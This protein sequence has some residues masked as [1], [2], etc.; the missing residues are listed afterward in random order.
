MEDHRRQ[1]GR[2]SAARRSL[3]SGAGAAK[4]QQKV[5]ARR[6][7]R[8]ATRCRATR[9]YEKWEGDSTDAAPPRSCLNNILI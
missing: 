5:D 6:S 7:S 8:A 2:R 1:V 3:G 4:E 9:E